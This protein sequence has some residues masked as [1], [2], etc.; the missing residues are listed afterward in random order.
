MPLSVAMLLGG[1][2]R[3]LLEQFI[4]ND[5]SRHYAFTPDGTG[6][7]VAYAYSAYSLVNLLW[8]HIA[9]NQCDLDLVEP[10][11]RLFMQEEDRLPRHGALLDYGTWKNL[12]EG[13]TSGYEHIVPSPNAERAWCFDRLADLAEHSGQTGASQLRRR[14]E[15]IR[16]EIREKLWDSSRGWFRCLY[17]GGHAEWV[18]SIQMFNALGTGTCTAEMRQ[19]MVSHLRDGAFLGEYGVSSIS[20]ADLLHYETGDPDWSGAGCYTGSGP[21]LAKLLWDEGESTLAWEVLRRL[22][23]M[24]KHLPYFPQEHYCDRPATPQRKRANIVSGLAGVEAIVAGLAGIRPQLSG[25]L[26][27]DPHPLKEGTVELSNYRFRGRQ[28]DLTIGKQ[29]IVKI[30]AKTVYSGQAGT[31]QILSG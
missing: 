19:A 23:W 1:Q 29:C 20:R 18:Y 10:V 3:G 22:L 21:L 24:G 27:I 31:M 5:I 7:G 17:P 9:Q 16:R 28:V 26:L 13:G 14:A 12:L 30:D 4:C 6:V 2:M 8:H 15:Q 25:S 11:Q